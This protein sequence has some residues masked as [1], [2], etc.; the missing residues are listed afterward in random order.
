[1]RKENMKQALTDA[2]REKHLAQFRLD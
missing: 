1:L 2:E